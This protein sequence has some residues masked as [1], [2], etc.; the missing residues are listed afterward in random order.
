MKEMKMDNAREEARKFLESAIVTTDA[1]SA[2]TFIQMSIAWSL[3]KL[4]EQIIDIDSTLFDIKLLLD[5][6]E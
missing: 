6:N 4:T 2:D 3:I 5:E 1:E